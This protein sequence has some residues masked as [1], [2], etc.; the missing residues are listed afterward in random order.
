MPIRILCIDDSKTICFIVA[1][2]LRPYDCL[3]S[4]AANGLE[5]L[6]AI[7]SEKPDL[8]ILDINMPV[9]DGFTMLTKLREDEALLGIPVIMLTGWSGQERE[10]QI[11][12]L[13][14]QDYLVKPFTKEQLI[15]KVGRVVSLQRKSTVDPQ[16]MTSPSA[17]PVSK[18]EDDAAAKPYWLEPIPASVACLA[19]L[20]AQQNVD[21]EEIARVI[22]KD[23]ALTKRLLKD[24]NL[25]YEDEIAN[26]ERAVA[27]KG[28]SCV[29]LLTMGDL[30]G[31]ALLKTFQTML[32]IK[33]ETLSSK[34][35]ELPAGLHIL[36]EVRF[37][38]NAFG[39]IALRLTQPSARVIASRML[40]L[41][42]KELTDTLR[43]DDA[44]CELTN[45]VAG[46]FLSNL[47]DA[48]LQSRLAPPKVRRT[49]EFEIWSIPGSMSERLAFRA[50]EI[51]IIVDIIVDPW[52][53]NN[54]LEP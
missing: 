47:A 39:R 26:V 50:S 33:L 19:A 12:A 11:A 9:M 40:R 42:P 18:V 3:V 32:E 29:L 16:G 2:A 13:K 25:E 20:V 35:I 21:L 36:S 53:G 1:S 22:I 4:E 28:I 31:R 38:G 17:P 30:V 6:A 45:M 54:P 34:T 10:L 23:P 51:I 27:L 8:I 24:T 5:G 43:I 48:G 44:I 41:D 52:K 46:N 7:A 49:D 15:E 14:V 37:S